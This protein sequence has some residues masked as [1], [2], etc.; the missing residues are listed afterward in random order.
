MENGLFLRK[1]SSEI[2][3]RK[4][5]EARLHT[6]R[7]TKEF[8]RN[9]EIRDK[10]VGNDNIGRPVYFVLDPKTLK[11]K[12]RH[13]QVFSGHEEFVRFLGVGGS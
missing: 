10:Y 12:R 11:V 9:L 6:D 4:F 7:N 13:D 2:L 8:A 1:P 3:H 5:V